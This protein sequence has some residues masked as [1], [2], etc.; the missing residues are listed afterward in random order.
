VALCFLFFVDV[1]REAVRSDSTLLALVSYFQER[2]DFGAFVPCG[3]T[4][5]R[6]LIL[7]MVGTASLLGSA[8][9]RQKRCNEELEEVT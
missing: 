1:I 7:T 2:D 9:V 8:G 3:H 4:D 6:L 5:P